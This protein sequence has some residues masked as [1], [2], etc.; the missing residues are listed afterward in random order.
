MSYV[1]MIVHNKYY[2]EVYKYYSGRIGKKIYNS[3]ATGKTPLKQL[4]YQDR[5]A[6]RFCRWKLDNNFKA[7]DLFITLTYK[8]DEKPASEQARKNISSLLARLRI[9]YKKIDKSLKYIYVAG[10]TKRGAVHFHIVLNKIDINIISEAWKKIAGGKVLAQSLYGREFGKL[11]SYLIKNSCETFYSNE[12]I[13]NKRY[14]SS[15]NLELPA[16][17][18]K[19]IGA[20]EW[21]KQPK[22]LKG[23]IIDKSSLYNGYGW[24]ECENGWNGCETQYYK[25]IPIEIT[26]YSKRKSQT[27]LNIPILD[28]DIERNVYH[29]TDNAI[30]YR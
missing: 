3:P 6:E 9:E 5:K 17:E 18:R 14:C 13:H 26:H 7:G 12:K 21:R 29:D 30:R 23:Y 19:I 10:R 2:H 24:L 1:K 20:K 28:Y 22:A 27:R 4:R 16:I 15:N 25:L 11:A 8:A